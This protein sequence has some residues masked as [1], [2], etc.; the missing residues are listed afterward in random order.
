MYFGASGNGYSVG[1]THIN[2]CDFSLDSWS[3]DDTVDD[4]DLKNFNTS[5][6]ERWMFPFIT[7]ALK[8]T[9]RPL[10][11]F[12]TPWSPPAWMKGNGQMDGSS[13]PGL[14][15]DPR[16]QDAWALFFS[17]SISDYKNRGIPVWGITIQNEPEFAAPWEACCYT[18]EQQ[19]AFL[20]QHLGPR[21][22]KDHPEVKIM[23]FDHNRDSLPVWVQT[24]MTDPV[25]RQ[26]AD[27][28]AFHWYVCDDCFAN[29]YAIYLPLS[30]HVL[31]SLTLHNLDLRPTTSRLINFYSPLRLA[32]AHPP[33]APGTRVRSMLRTSLVI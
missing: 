9:V 33:P 21:M 2:S 30:A 26:Y 3:F 19:L 1:R 18:P 22:R 20:T 4:F 32:R 13:Q 14:K 8:N 31:S 7:S 12:L 15:K 6:N 24:I 29:V 17:K 11:L 5:H 28:S 25:G 10:R 16:Y 27:G 23:I